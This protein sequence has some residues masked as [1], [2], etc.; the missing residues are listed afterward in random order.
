[1]KNEQNKE[2][3]ELTELQKQEL[4]DLQEQVNL[5]L[6]KTFSS[7]SLYEKM[8][9]TKEHAEKQ[10]QIYHERYGVPDKAKLDAI[11]ENH[12]GDLLSGLI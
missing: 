8:G 1:M 10:I 7:P 4:N 5:T 12:L 11:D 9:I 6:Y 2:P 3:E